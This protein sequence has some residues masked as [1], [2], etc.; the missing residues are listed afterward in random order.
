[1][2]FDGGTCGCDAM[3]VV[4]LIT[5]MMVVLW[6]GDGRTNCRKDVDGRRALNINS[7]IQQIFIENLQSKF[8]LVQFSH[9]VLSNSL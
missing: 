1:M 3:M 4:M 7:F 6:F 2:W 8:I 9:S 5:G